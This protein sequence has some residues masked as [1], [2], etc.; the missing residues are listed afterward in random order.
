METD[1]NEKLEMVK[2]LNWEYDVEPEELLEVIEEKKDRAGPF[3]AQ[4][5]FIRSLERMPWH[6]ILALWGVDRMKELYTEDLARKVW[7]ASLRRLC[8]PKAWMAA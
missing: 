2:S 8:I 3:D 7:P 1:R 4:L 6:R 5:L